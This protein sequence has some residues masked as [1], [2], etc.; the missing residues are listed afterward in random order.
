MKR[1][2]IKND[3]LCSVM[4]EI[5]GLYTV[6]EISRLYSVY[7]ILGLCTVHEICYGY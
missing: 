4:Y 3:V 7:E 6:Y 2:K 1:V 5:L